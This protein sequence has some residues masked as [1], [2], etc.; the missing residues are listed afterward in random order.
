MSTYTFSN[1][2]LT[3]HLAIYKDGILDGL[4][5]GS[6]IFLEEDTN[7]ATIKKGNREWRIKPADVSGCSTVADV[8]D[9]ILANM[10]TFTI[11]G[12]GGGSSSSDCDDATQTEDLTVYASDFVGSTYTIPGLNGRNII[13]FSNSGSGVLLKEGKHY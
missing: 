7:W 6:G 12:S 10:P 8:M 13:V 2:V 4:L 3:G 1:S 5:A 9:E 11:G